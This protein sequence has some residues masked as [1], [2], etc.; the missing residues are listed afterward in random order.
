MVGSEWNRWELH[1]HTPQTKKNDCFT[2]GKISE[3]WEKY[4]QCIEEYI[5]E[6]KPEKNI[7]ALAVT[8]YLSID[9]YLK[10]QSDKKLPPSIELVMPNV[11]LR[12]A[13]KPN[14]KPINFHC[15]FNPTF[16]DQLI[17]RFFSKLKF[18]NGERNL[19][20]TKNELICLGKSLDPNLKDEGAFLKKGIDNFI[21][22]LSC[23]QEIFT[24]DKELRE[25]TLLIVANKQ[26]D[27]A[28][29]LRGDQYTGIKRTLYRF[30]DA[31]FSGTASDIQY[32]LG[33]KENE[34]ITIA[35]NGK[36]MPCFHGS[37][38]HCFEKIFEPDLR[39][40]CYI[41]SEVTFEGL[42]QT[43]TDPEDRVFIGEKPPVL[44]RIEMNPEKIIKAIKLT[45]SENSDASWFKEE[46]IELNPQLNVIIGNKGAGKTALA[47]IIGLCAN[48]K[49]YED[50]VFLSKFK[51][52]KQ[53][54]ETAAY[55]IYKN[56]VKT[57]EKYFSEYIE[58]KTETVKYLPQAY[59][60]SLTNEIEKVENFRLELENVIF[61]YLSEQEKEHSQSFS[62]Y[63][64]SIGN[65]EKSKITSLQKKI[66]KMNK[67][68]IS[69]EDR[70]SLKRIKQ[71]ESDVIE[72]QAV[73]NAHLK[74]EP[75]KISIG[76][77]SNNQNK[78]LMK[79]E[80]RLKKLNHFKRRIE[81][82]LNRASSR[83]RK[84]EEFHFELQKRIDDVSVYIDSHENLFEEL[85]FE[86]GFTYSYN[87]ESLTELINELTVKIQRY[88][89]F[90]NEKSKGNFSRGNTLLGKIDFYNKQIA[91][92]T[93]KES[94]EFQKLKRLKE[95]YDSWEKKRIILLGDPQNP[96]SNSL[97]YLEKELNYIKGDLQKDLSV[98]EAER[99]GLSQEIMALK[100]IVLKKFENATHAIRMTLKENEENKM[101]VVNEF[102]LDQNFTKQF[103]SNIN[104]ARISS[105]RGTYEGEEHLKKLV[106]N[107]LTE[108]ADFSNIGK[109]LNSIME[110]LKY[111]EKNG[112]RR[113]I[114]LS[115]I[116]Y[117]RQNLYDY[118]FGMNYIT[119]EFDLRLQD[120]KLEQ[121]SPGE[122]GA[123][124]LIFYLVLDKDT[125]PLLIDQPEDNLD[126]QSVA[127]ILV[128]YIKKAKNRRQVIM[129]THNPNLAVVSDAELV[130]HVT[131]DKEN[132]NTFSCLSGGIENPMIN[133]KIQDILEGTS[134]A[135]KTRD[136]K[137]Q[138]C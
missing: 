56:G 17:D 119:N 123:V 89:K 125:V 98:L 106:K 45:K 35:N 113:N 18:H 128:P 87:K 8:D 42:K 49:R 97:N 133:K 46:K 54:K 93:S 23:L 31:I 91:E 121:L 43:L 27:G 61:Q 4:Y 22:E 30:V 129:V 103:L 67:E 79:S 81:I 68:I 9:N 14:S 24:H 135:F 86:L 7:K 122:R 21:V 124:L 111:V 32:F 58:E 40:Y 95:E 44:K 2:G 65:I 107:Y 12:L 6:T 84:L 130:I 36:L 115:T 120:K 60:E 102:V 62:E 71:L 96:N 117:N 34:S 85:D 41:K 94:E 72:V 16:V 137:Y 136:R 109:F 116:I 5:D 26:G 132:S 25:N 51:C 37:D 55:L 47:D 99:L 70:S 28:S 92:L 39:R 10:V 59:F 77:D 131:I 69:L 75:Q 50:F 11:E 101:T 3:N 114:D 108:Y 112:D 76:K 20:A 138:E 53:A 134:K 64:R 66:S 52:T 19:S 48:S 90:I 33:K 38:A 74:M 57:K 105:Y 110:S 73:L 100:Q 118:L 127:N 78:P 104:Q 1:I 63:R 83:K 126:N 80:E 13:L 15:I 82:E 88:N 29:G